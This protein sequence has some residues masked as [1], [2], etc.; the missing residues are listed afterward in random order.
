MRPVVYRYVEVPVRAMS[1]NLGGPV[2]LTRI[3]SDEE[4]H[5]HCAICGHRAI[6]QAD[7]AAGKEEAAKEKAQWMFCG[8][9]ILFVVMI[10]LAAMASA[11][12]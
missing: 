9:C 8:F 7:V 5:A 4:V 3:D 10:I 2:S 12:N 1:L 11:P 6:T